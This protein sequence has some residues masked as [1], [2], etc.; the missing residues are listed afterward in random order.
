MQPRPL[1]PLGDVRGRYYL[2]FQVHDRP[3]VLARLAGA[4]G[5]AAVSIEQ[6]VQEGGAGS[7]GLPVDSVMLT[8]DALERDVN[9][10]LEA[11][12]RSGVAAA[13]P[14]VIRIQD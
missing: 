2:R 12:A 8:H 10:A 5:E 7:S 6:M 1:T 13:A 11:I 9:R 4:L 3:G 14:R